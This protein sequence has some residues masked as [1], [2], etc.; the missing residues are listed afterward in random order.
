M[1]YIM[2]TRKF[3]KNLT[4]NLTK[5][6]LL[7]NKT[8][9]KKPKSIRKSIKMRKKRKNNK[10][11]KSPSK[12]SSKSSNEVTC[13]ICFDEIDNK[14][15][16]VSLKCNHIYHKKCI[17]PWCNELHR[18]N[19]PC[20]CPMCREKLEEKELKQLGELDLNN[21]QSVYDIL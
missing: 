14:N 11:K 2:A 1:K 7:L 9:K 19:K 6:S 4:K 17:K 16:T 13:S 21:Q 10:S 15:E 5:K 3:S 18:K 8:I 20:T 12:S